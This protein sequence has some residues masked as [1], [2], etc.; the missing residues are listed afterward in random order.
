MQKVAS[1]MERD[2]YCAGLSDDA[3]LEDDGQKTVRSAVSL[4]NSLP[5]S[6]L[7]V[8][9][10]RGT[11]GDYVSNLRPHSPIYA[12]S[13][14]YEACPK[15]SLNWGTIPHYLAFDPNPNRTIGSAIN[16]LVQEGLAKSGDHP[17]I[18]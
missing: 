15:L 6:K 9:T 11:M 13:P 2:H 16:T 5:D 7:V 8:F 4:A 18:V 1:R 14:T 12:F 10:R 17:V 3:I